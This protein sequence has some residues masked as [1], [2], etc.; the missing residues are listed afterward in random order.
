M[1]HVGK[2]TIYPLLLAVYPTLALLSFNIGEARPSAGVRPMLVSLAGALALWLLFRLLLRDAHRAA[3]LSAVWMILFFSYGHVFTYLQD[4]T[5]FGLDVAR[6]QVLAPLWVVMAALALF[7]ATRPRVRFEAWASSL[8]LITAALVVFPLA[9]VVWHQVEIQN[10]QDGAVEAPVVVTD[11]RP[12][13]YYIILDSYTR[14]DTLSAAYGYDNSAFLG[15]LEAMGF[16]VAECGMSNYVRTELSMASSLNMTY[17]TSDLDSR[18][19]PESQARSPLWRLMRDSAV[20]EYLEARGYKTVA[21]ATGFPWSE[22]DD[23]DVYLQPDPLRGGLTEFETLFLRTTAAR[24]LQDEGL[25]NFQQAEFNRYRQR[26]SFALATLESLPHMDGPKFV[27]AHLLIPH[28]P[29][30]FDENGGKVDSMSYLNEEGIYPA[31]EYAEGY[32]MQL[33]FINREMTRM[34]EALIRESDVPPVI[35]I[36]GDH[37]PWVQTK[38]RRLTILNAYYLPGH[39]SEIYETITPV[40]TFRIIFNAYL[41]GDFELLEDHSYFSPVPK[42]YDFTEIPNRCRI[43]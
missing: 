5:I 4:K 1:K 15:G 20:R 19:N 35:V 21:F 43:R 33:T 2:L 27:F 31:K 40:N 3:F 28:P 17:L 41:D 11:E 38:E 18:I 24:V 9:Q 32:T 26:T 29:F 37:G 36:Q 10:M 16:E 42:Q 34:V 23:A 8:N 7:A 14:A 39:G 13:I 25:V 22:L 12:D 30:V 6:T